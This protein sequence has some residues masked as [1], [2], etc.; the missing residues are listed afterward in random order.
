MSY[1]FCITINNPSEAD[2]AGFGSANIEYSIYQIEKG[3]NGTEHA[4]G[5]IRMYRKSRC[6]AV[7]RIFPRAHIEIA[8]GSIEDNIKYC[9]KEETRVRG[10]FESGHPPGNQGA[11]SDIHAFRDALLE[12]KSDINLVQEFP[13]QVAKFPRFI[14]FCRRLAL[15]PRSEKPVVRVYWGESGSGKTREAFSPGDTYVVSRPDTGRPLWWDGYAG[16]RVTILDDFYGWIPWSYLLQLLDRYPF[17]VEVKGGKVNFNS[18]EIYITSNTHP[19]TWY[20]NIPNG[21]LK[22]LLRRID[23]IK[24]FTLEPEC[25]Q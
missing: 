22:P 3:S 6:S 11:R 18:P 16:H 2:L 1:N 10:P 9:S 14:D 12:G 8:R 17:A 23:E 13:L 4:Q 15:P 7:K 24:H 25:P 19:E 20:K 21:D 5:F